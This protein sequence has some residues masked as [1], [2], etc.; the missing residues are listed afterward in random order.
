M[1]LLAFPFNLNSLQPG[2][3]SYVA[4]GSN[5]QKAQEIAAFWMTHKGERPIF[6]EY[7]VDDPTF[8]TF[9]ESSFAADFAS[10]YQSD[11]ELSSVE[12]LEAGNAITDIN[13]EFE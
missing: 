9:D 7:G 8:H 6:N 13:V 3:L 1:N 10:F 2:V 11:I 12:I 5:A 4:Q